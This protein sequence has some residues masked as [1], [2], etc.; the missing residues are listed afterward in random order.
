M[1]RR[2]TKALDLLRNA[3][4][5]VHSTVHDRMDTMG[6]FKLRGSAVDIQDPE[7]RERYC[8]VLYERIKW[9]PTD[10]FHLFAFDIESAAHIYYG[11][12]K[13]HVTTWTPAGGVV[14]QVVDSP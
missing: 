1:M 4:C 14:A 9:R 5:V 7:K 8:Q 13:K 6:E 3:R 12:E 10:D 2:S 11:D